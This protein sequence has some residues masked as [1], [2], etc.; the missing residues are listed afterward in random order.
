MGWRTLFD[1]QLSKIGL[2]V[3]SS[4]YYDTHVL[5]EFVRVTSPVLPEVIQKMAIIY[6]RLDV[7]ASALASKQHLHLHPHAA[8]PAIREIA[9]QKMPGRRGGNAPLWHLYELRVIESVLRLPTKLQPLAL[10]DR[11]RS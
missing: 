5:P 6:C 3:P 10:C 8:D 7:I 11:Y 4:R 2:E 9:V 1:I